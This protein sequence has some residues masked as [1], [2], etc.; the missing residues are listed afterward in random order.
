M[1]FWDLHT[2]QCLQTSEAQDEPLLSLAMS[3]EKGYLFSG[4]ASGLCALW[5]LDWKLDA[6]PMANEWDPGADAY[7][8]A[9]LEEHARPLETTLTRGR[10]EPTESRWSQA[11]FA[12]LMDTLAFAQ[13]GWI[14]KEAV[15]KRLMSMRGSDEPESVSPLRRFKDWYQKTGLFRS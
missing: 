14:S 10:R 12:T 1:K 2:R 3:A 11:A 4:G 8:K 5:L 6:A 9:F 7:L 15:R 13:Y